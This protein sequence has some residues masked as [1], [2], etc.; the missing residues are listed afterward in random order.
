MTRVPPS[1]VKPKP[2][3]AP[4]APNRPRT[5]KTQQ[6]TAAQKAQEIK[7]DEQVPELKEGAQQAGE[8]QGGPE[9][10]HV[11]AEHG[12]AVSEEVQ[13]REDRL[14]HHERS[15]EE[16][17]KHEQQVNRSSKT[18]HE[19]GAN[20]Q[21]QSGSGSETKTTRQ[22]K[23]DGF[24]GAQKL[25]ASAVNLRSLTGLKETQK[26]ATPTLNVPPRPGGNLGDAM[27]AL[28]NAQDPGVFFK[29]HDAGGRPDEETEDPELAAAVEECIRMLFGVRGIL[30]VGPGENDAGEPVVLI[31]AARGFTAQS[32]TQVPP[33]VHRF[34]TLLALPFE[35]L[36]LKRERL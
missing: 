20:Q 17:R 1:N 6:T 25:E 18:V 2:A 29:E 16:E 8:G 36:P 15:A 19:K 13:N 7:A 34:K 33:T 11:G 21:Q 3:S 14:E 26:V 9:W 23:K 5:S 24:E 4:Q 27:K 12:A 35:L 28:H 22:L 32:M 31:S 10:Q 30:R